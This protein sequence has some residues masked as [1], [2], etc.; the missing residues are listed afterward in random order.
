M[1]TVSGNVEIGRR[2]FDKIYQRILVSW[3]AIIKGYVRNNLWDE[4]LALFCQ[5]KQGA[6]N[7]DKFTFPL[8]M[9]ACESLLHLEHGKEIHGYIIG[10]IFDLDAFVEIA[11]IDMYA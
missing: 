7:T 8:V 1:Y 4:V 5:M 6:I 2:V 3:N 11:L 10:G 9:K